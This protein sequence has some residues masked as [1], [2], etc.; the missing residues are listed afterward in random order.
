MG[1]PGKT[2]D[3]NVNAPSRPQQR[4]VPL[5]PTAPEE[6]QVNSESTLHG[7]TPTES[8]PQYPQRARRPPQ[9]HDLYI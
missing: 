4:R 1:L 6:D 5:D 3:R 2:Q 8:T 9:H 7:T